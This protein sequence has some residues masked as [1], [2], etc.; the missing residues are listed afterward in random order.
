M[1][2]STFLK[3]VVL[4]IVL[5]RNER[6]TLKRMTKSYVVTPYAKIRWCFYV[7]DICNSAYTID[8]QLSII[9]QTEV[10]A[11]YSFNFIERFT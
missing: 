5:I 8:S 6:T 11:F 2:V 7:I 10:I 9:F 4:G 3:Y 1:N